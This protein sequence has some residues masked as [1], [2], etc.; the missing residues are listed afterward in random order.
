[1]KKICF[2]LGHYFEYSK[3]GAE[4]QAYLM[5]KELSKNFEVHYIFVKPLVFDKERIRRIDE[6]FILHIMR[7]HD[8]RVLGKLFFLNYN[9]LFKLLDGIDPDV[10]YQR[11]DRAHL[12]IAARWCKKNDKKLIFGISMD[13]N[14]IR[15]NKFIFNENLL[16]Y[17]SKI[18]NDFF[19]LI[20]IRN[21]DLIIAQTNRQQQLLN[22]NFKKDSIVIPNGL[23][24]PTL[25]FKKID[26]PIISWIAN[27]KPLKKPE[28][29]IKLA[30]KC[31]DLNIKFVYA[32]RSSENSYQNMLME[33]S[34]K[35]PNLTYLGEI[36]Y[37]KTNELLSKSSLLVNTSTTEGF[38]NT[39]IQAW[40]RETPVVTLNCDPDNIIKNQRI[41]FHSGS[42]E[43]LVMDVRYLIENEDIRREMGEKARIYSIDNHDIVKIS[44]RYLEIIENLSH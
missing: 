17:P 8:Y 33:K 10:V 20:G 7:N 36:S 27:I 16:S 25:P 26:P 28:I 42:F 30:E 43:K 3:G 23:P 4:L 15:K 24:V 44:K 35:L 37:Q 6:G 29:F 22:K 12:G 34:K 39:Y 32:G 40:M 41:G 5:A 11:G 38:S 13:L 14:C 9:E 18:I 31:Q 21:A 19:T 2:L 1:M